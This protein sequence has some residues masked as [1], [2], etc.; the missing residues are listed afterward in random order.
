MPRCPRDS[1]ESSP[2]PQFESISSS[3]L[4]LLSGP[5]LTS[6]HDYW[7]NHSWNDR[8]VAVALARLLLEY[9]SQFFFQVFPAFLNRKCTQK[10]LIQITKQIMVRNEKNLIFPKRSFLWKDVVIF[11]LFKLIWKSCCESQNYLQ[12]IWNN[13]LAKDSDIVKYYTSKC[14]HTCVHACM[15]V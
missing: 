7:K 14:V 3:V 8:P 12:R 2:A 15:C 6:I 11:S 5:T 10:C 13:C 1:Q 9:C 4:S